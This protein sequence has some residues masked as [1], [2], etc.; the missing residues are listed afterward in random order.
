M[1]RRVLS[2]RTASS[3]LIALLLGVAILW[4]YIGWVLDTRD[5]PPLLKGA[6][7]KIVGAAG[8]V[9]GIFLLVVTVPMFHVGLIYKAVAL[10]WVLF[11]VRH[12]LLFFRNI[13][14][15]A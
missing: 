13:R 9:F 15:D 4:C 7:R 10:V 12:F 3:E 8:C 14:Q 1:A 5:N 11:I 2:A 6:L